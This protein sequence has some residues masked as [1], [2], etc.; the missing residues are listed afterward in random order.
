MIVE[1]ETIFEIYMTNITNDKE[2]NDAIKKGVQPW[3]DELD[4][5]EVR[6][7]KLTF[8][9]TTDTSPSMLAEIRAT[10]NVQVD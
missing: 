5:D 3:L 9:I 4:K 6:Y 7:S 8:Y 10:V 2:A 1:R